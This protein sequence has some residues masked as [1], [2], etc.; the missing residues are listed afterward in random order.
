MHNHVGPPVAHAAAAANLSGA[1][2]MATLFDLGDLDAQQP[3]PVE[4]KAANDEDDEVVEWTPLGIEQLHA[5]MFDVCLAQ[6]KDP[7]TPLDEVFDWLRW[8]IS[9]PRKRDAPF[10]FSSVMRLHRRPNVR[11]V[12]ETV[13]SGARRFIAKRLSAYPPI[14]ADTFWRNPDLFVARLDRNPQWVNEML[15]KQKALEPT[16]IT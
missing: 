4:V 1:A 13:L 5:V 9:D 3:I 6:L 14:V 12:Q 11:D 2:P 16:P 15:R 7:E 10:S 8:V